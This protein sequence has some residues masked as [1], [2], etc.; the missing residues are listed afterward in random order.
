MS[1]RIEGLDPQYAARLYKMLDRYFNEQELRSLMFGLGVD[2]DSLAGAGKSDKAR[3]LIGYMFRRGSLEKLLLGVNR[4]RPNVPWPY[5]PINEP[6]AEPASSSFQTRQPIRNQPTSTPVAGTT[7]PSR[8]VTVSELYPAEDSSSQTRNPL[9]IGGIVAGIIILLV[10][11]FLIYQAV[12]GDNEAPPVANGETN[13]AEVSETGFNEENNSLNDPDESD[14]VTNIETNNNSDETT[15]SNEPIGGGNEGNSAVPQTSKLLAFVRGFGTNNM[16]IFVAQEDGSGATQITNTTGQNW[17]PAWSPDGRQ[18][19]FASDRDENNELY[20]M[21]TNGNN[22]RR[23]TNTAVD[24]FFPSWSPDGRSLV[25]YRTDTNGINRD[26]FT[27]DISTGQV[28]QLTNHPADDTYPVWSPSSGKIA[29]TSERDGIAAIYTINLDGTGL[30]RLTPL[31]S[32]NWYPAWSPDG[33][34]IAFH[35]NR[36]GNYEIYTMR[37]DGTN[38]T[39]ITMNSTDDY[40][41]SWSGDGAHIVFHTTRDGE[42]EIYRMEANGNNQ[43]RITVNT[44]DDRWAAWQP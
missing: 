16:E 38:Q 23:L 17:G 29:F 43:T 1:D 3:E 27:L 13:N 18:I 12:T 5:P 8:N 6:F 24:E 22:Q 15:S 26:I 14:N 21:D 11:S 19:A 9:L 36:D 25:Y 34:L 42:R 35:S 41:P 10:G 39:R 33:S 40:S 2:Y 30:Q 37:P 20:V 28:Q 31:T 44:L 32:E 7:P 4:E